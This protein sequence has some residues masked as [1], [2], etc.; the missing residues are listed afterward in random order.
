MNE[1]SKGAYFTGGLSDKDAE[2]EVADARLAEGP[3]DPEFFF[4]A[5][6]APRN[7]SGGG[8]GGAVQAPRDESGGGTRGAVQVHQV[9]VQHRYFVTK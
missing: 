3:P 5:S 1:Y 2:Q 8:I 6:S 7:E 9:Q 4:L